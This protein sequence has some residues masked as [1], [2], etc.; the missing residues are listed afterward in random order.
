MTEQG[1]WDVVNGIRKH[2][3]PQQ[4]QFSPMASREGYH[5]IEE[6]LYYMEFGRAYCGELVEKVAPILGSENICKRCSNAYED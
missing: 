6:W 5:I 2:Q 3:H 4:I 1:V